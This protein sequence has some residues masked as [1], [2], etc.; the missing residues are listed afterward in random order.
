MRLRVSRSGEEDALGRSAYEAFRVSDVEGWLSYFRDHS[1]RA[2]EDTIVAEEDG[3][4]LGHATALRLAMRWRGRELPF[5]G[6]AAVAV[7]PEARR[8]GIAARLLDEIHRRMRARGEALALL[9]PFSVPFYERHGYGVV[10]WAELLRVPP[11]ALPAS[12]LRRRVRRLD[13]DRDGAALR[14]LY[15]EA[16]T[17]GHGLIARDDYWW[18]ERVLARAPERVGYFDDGGLRGYLLYEVPKEPDY[19]EQRVVVKELVAAR[20]DAH[21][22]LLGFLEALGEQFVEVRFTLG[23]GTAATLSRHPAHR[24]ADD[25]HSY[26]PACTVVSGA[27]ARIV[28]VPAAL[29]LLGPAPVRGRLGLDVS[30]G[31]LRRYDVEVGPRGLRA[32][33]GQ[34]ARA[35][36]ALPISRLAQVVF[37]APGAARLL[38]QGHI[39]GSPDAAALVDAA[40]AGPPPFLSRLNFF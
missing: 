1:A 26:Q 10:E 7:V 2:P 37:A 4:L 18:R 9:Y 28:D 12:P 31:R 19:P 36:L 14:A 27:M 33:P 11:A 30:D 38:E 20:A 25:I 34:R 32:A 17:R 35:R 21:R 22:G 24:T 6:V 8:R 15:D 40:C 5:R 29:A 13:L 3:A 39:E 16:R 23:P